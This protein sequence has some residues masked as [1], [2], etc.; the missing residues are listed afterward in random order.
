MCGVERCNWNCVLKR[1]MGARTTQESPAWWRAC[2]V[3]ARADGHIGIN[4]Q[5]S[6]KAPGNLPGALNDCRETQPSD[7]SETPRCS[8]LISPALPTHGLAGDTAF[9]KCANSP[10]NQQ[11]RRP[12]TGLVSHVPWMALRA[13]AYSC[14]C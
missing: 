3:S 6:F 4:R 11:R 13:A 9:V 8:V 10:A 2:A 1:S 12:W 7:R 5:Q 14:V